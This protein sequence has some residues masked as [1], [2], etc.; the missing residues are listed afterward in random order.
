[1]KEKLIDIS[2][3][4]SSFIFFLICVV[5]F[6]IDIKANLKATIVFMYFFIRK[7]CDYRFTGRIGQFSP[8]AQSTWKCEWRL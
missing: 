3:S 7:K 1:M 4:G 6:H 5:S 2:T 8:I